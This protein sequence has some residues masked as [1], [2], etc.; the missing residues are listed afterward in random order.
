MDLLCRPVPTRWNLSLFLLFAAYGCGEVHGPGPGGNQEQRA[1]D[2]GTAVVS[3]GVPVRP[4]PRAFAGRTGAAGFGPSAG[5]AAR[6]VAGEGAGVAGQPWPEHGCPAI[7]CPQGAKFKTNFPFTFEVARTALFEVCRNDYCVSGQ[8][9]AAAEPPTRG[10][11]V[12]IRAP[13]VAEQDER[14]WAELTLWGEQSG[15]FYL[16]LH[17]WPWSSS[18]LK[19]GDHY[20]L[21]VR[22]ANGPA[23]KLLDQSVM[24]NDSSFGTPGS[25]CY[26]PCQLSDLDLRGSASPII[27]EDAGAAP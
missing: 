22:P 8:L 9:G 15:G 18:D 19:S 23:K 4:D 12:G 16:D 3:G 5:R 26:Q 21:I 6:P 25:E 1:E 11:G 14:G 7:A 13:S 10:T 17:W 27:D 24:Y 20:S 2:P